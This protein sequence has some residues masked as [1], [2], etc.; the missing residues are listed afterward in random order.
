M[1]AAQLTYQYI[2]SSLGWK[3]VSQ[4][5]QLLT[6]GRVL[7]WGFD[8]AGNN[9]TGRVRAADCDA[10]YKVELSLFDTD[11]SGE[12]CLSSRCTCSAKLDCLHAAA[13][14]LTVLEDL[15]GSQAELPAGTPPDPPLMEP[16]ASRPALAVNW[17]NKLKSSLNCNEGVET[18]EESVIY[19]FSVDR[20]FTSGQ[21][22]VEP[23]VARRLKSGSYGTERPYGWSQLASGRARYVK[24]TDRDIASLWVAL[25][26]P[27]FQVSPA[28]PLLPPRDPDV[29]SL[30]LRRIIATGQAFY[31][32]DRHRPLK[33]GDAR[34]G[35]VEWVVHS[36]A[37]QSV[38]IV[39]KEPGL[40]LMSS[41]G[42][43]VCQSGERRNRLSQLAV[44][45]RDPPN[46]AC[47]AQSCIGG[48]R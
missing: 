43:W 13:V 9:V 40:E 33:L 48:S 8:I 10:V 17:L 42:P 38:E 18:G 31:A 32:V 44:F 15:Q 4:A 47:L 25:S 46:L 28:R 45:R 21:L 26:P 14:A 12:T 20:R 30:L 1:P 3:A 23:R 11:E 6:Q 24:R 39:L 29:L 37:R 16:V 7:D 5:R 34:E 2:S 41:T 19:V 35:A 22:L 36:D 27:D